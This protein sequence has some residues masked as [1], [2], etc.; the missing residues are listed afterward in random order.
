MTTTATPLCIPATPMPPHVLVV[1]IL[2]DGFKSAHILRHNTEDLQQ[3]FMRW[4][5]RLNIEEVYALWHGLQESHRENVRR[6]LFDNKI[7]PLVR[8]PWHGPS[9]AK[10]QAKLR[11]L[12]VE[13]R[14]EWDAFHI[15]ACTDYEFAGYRRVVLDT[16]IA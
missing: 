4:L 6:L 10:F 5:D 16:R 9:V 1:F 11:Q 14:G 7:D 8:S 3:A 2:R 13:Y 12:P 15:Y